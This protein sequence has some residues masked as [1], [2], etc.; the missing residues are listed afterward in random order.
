MPGLLLAYR[1]TS[2][3]STGEKPSYLLVGLDCRSPTEFTLLP[4]PTVEPTEVSDY[5]EELVLSLSHVRGLATSIMQ[6]AQREH[7]MIKRLPLV[8]NS[9][10]ET[11]FFNSIPPRRIWE[12]EEVVSIVAWPLQ[13]CVV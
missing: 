10:Q 2:H 11:G 1:N 9:V 7:I 5:R 13:S 8:S 3:E 6:A 12:V 4:A